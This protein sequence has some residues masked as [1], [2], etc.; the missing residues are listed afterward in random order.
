MP[1]LEDSIRERAWQLLGRA[2]TWHELKRMLDAEGLTD[3]LGA[4]G[5]QDLLA[6][7]HARAAAELTDAQL[8]DELGFWAEGGSY[9]THL[10][11]FQAVPA[12]ALVEAARSRGWFVRSGASGGAIVNPPG[13]RPLRVPLGLAG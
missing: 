13:G 7:W 10:K 5:M 12:A 11:G 8:Q 6:A 3:R 9:A 1:D 4:A 2:P